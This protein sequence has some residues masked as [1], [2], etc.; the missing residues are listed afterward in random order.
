M[1]KDEAIDAIVEAVHGFR[2]DTPRAVLRDAVR[3]VVDAMNGLPIVPVPMRLVCPEC[4]SLHIDVGEFAT[5][6][7]HTHACQAC[8]AVWRPAVPCTVGVR[9][10]PGFKNGPDVAEDTG[11]GTGVRE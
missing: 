11:P 10:L 3:G 4:A 9:F 8:G 1:T 6:P 5:K 2:G 7:H